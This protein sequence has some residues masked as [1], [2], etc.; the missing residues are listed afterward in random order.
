M[1][2][3]VTVFF[4][5]LCPFSWRAAELADL[6]ASELGLGFRWHHFSLMQ[7]NSEDPDYQIWNEQL[8]SEDPSGTGGLYPFLASLAAR[9]QGDDAGERFRLEL[10]RARHRD[11]RQLTPGT[12]ARVVDCTGLDAQRFE[13]DLQ[14]PELRTRLAQDHHRARCLRVFG[15][16]IFRFED[17]EDSGY[18][19]IS[20]VP[21][22]AG[23]AV[24]LFTVFREVLTEFPYLETIRRPRSN[25]N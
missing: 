3:Q 18:L 9:R 7:N 4:D 10:L 23:E 17:S 2:E 25:G 22:D 20:E 14:D 6:A 19:R 11:H 15:T 5:Y 1:P 12:I 16:P 21:R 24:R 8:N 13:S